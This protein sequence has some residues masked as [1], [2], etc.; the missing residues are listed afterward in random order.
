MA[1]KL[2]VSGS[3]IYSNPELF[4]ELFWEDI[5]HIEIGEFPDEKALGRFLKLSKEKHT[6]FG[7]HSPLLRGRSKYDLIEKVEY[8]SAYAWE[9]LESEA[10]R[11]SA[12][13]AEYLL[14]HFP[15]FKE[16]VQMNTNGLIEEGLRKLSCIQE[17]YSIG[18]V[19]EP[20]LGL[21]RSS[22]GINYLNNL[23]LILIL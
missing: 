20:K 6:N 11:M 5:E 9:Q 8:D 4:S 1:H 16:E 10:K 18:L 21:N 22:A 14:V 15:Y 3:T 13:G 23:N 19:C 17:K 2:G 7:V 12:L